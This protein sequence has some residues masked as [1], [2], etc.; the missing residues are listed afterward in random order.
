MEAASWVSNITAH[1]RQVQK[2][3]TTTRQLPPYETTANM[4]SMYNTHPTLTRCLATNPTGSNN[5]R[6]EDQEHQALYKDC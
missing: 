5:N 2:W 4:I 3:L 6:L 1:F